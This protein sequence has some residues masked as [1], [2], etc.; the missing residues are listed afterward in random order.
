MILFGLLAII[1][2]SS[3]LR[4]ILNIKIHKFPQLEG[5]ITVF[6]VFFTLLVFGTVYYSWKLGGRRAFY[7]TTIA[8][9]AEILL[10]NIYSWKWGYAVEHVNLILA[11]WLFL[12][13]AE[14]PADENDRLLWNMEKEK[15]DME[16][17]KKDLKNQL[18][19]YKRMQGDIIAAGDRTKQTL[20]TLELKSETAVEVALK[21][22]RHDMANKLGAPLYP[23]E[24]AGQ[25]EYWDFVDTIR[26][27]VVTPVVKAVLE[28]LSNLP[29]AIDTKLS[30]TPLDEVCQAIKDWFESEKKRSARF[31]LQLSDKTELKDQVGHCTINHYRLRTILSDIYGNSCA[32]ISKMKDRAREVGETYYGKIHFELSHS[33]GSLDI[34][35]TD[36]AGGFPETILPR[37]YKEPVT[38][39]KNP[40]G[41]RRGE[42]AYYAG[43]FI[44]KLMS[45]RIT[46]S[47]ET[48]DDGKMGAKTVIS[49]PIIEKE[50]SENNRKEPFN[51]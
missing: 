1:P 33:D 21:S 34:A 16:K 20:Q 22:L 3:S 15:W 25:N 43:F 11:I 9:N 4:V 7:F 40:N 27:D 42:G 49:L 32:A 31:D 41:E 13:K 37:I 23:V 5:T 19:I 12:G 8:W 38:S 26:N 24:K 30:T 10:Y 6:I 51:D 48:D 36:N 35:I 18:L 39:S 14:S 47:N 17:E 2:F 45:G 46:A 50:Q 29:D 28:M 44:E